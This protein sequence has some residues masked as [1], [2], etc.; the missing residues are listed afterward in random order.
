MN[1]NFRKQ[2]KGEE[3]KQLSERCVTFSVAHSDRI[4]TEREINRQKDYLFKYRIQESE[5][6]V[7][8][9]EGFIRWVNIVYSTLL[10]S[11]R[12]L[13]LVAVSSI[14]LFFY[15]F[16]LFTDTCF[17]KKLLQG[18]ILYLF[19]THF[20]SLTHDICIVSQM[21]GFYVAGTLI[22]HKLAHSQPMP[23]SNRNKLI[24]LYFKLTDWFLYERDIDLK[25]V[26]LTS[27]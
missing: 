3:T 7:N 24:D 21:T 5:I 6:N 13:Y 23:H 11:L 16:S 25:W 17:L 26:R 2:S 14:F 12:A 27:Q 9:F 10:F 15:Q 4:K 18:F 8:G 1:P 20:N 19:L 22:L